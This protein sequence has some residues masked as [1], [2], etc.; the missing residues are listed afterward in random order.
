MHVVVAWKTSRG[1][2]E[3]PPLPE[4]QPV[5]SAG[6]FEAETMSQTGAGAGDKRF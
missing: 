5:G 2:E 4:N 6:L 1:D 3:S